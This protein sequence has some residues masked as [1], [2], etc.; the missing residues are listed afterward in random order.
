MQ[1][2]E[3]AWLNWFDLQLKLL[4]MNY[5]ADN[6]TESALKVF[7]FLGYQFEDE[8]SQRPEVNLFPHFVS[9]KSSRTSMY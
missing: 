6:E 8:M 9:I 1:P 7:G 3:L 2:M 4:N 5:V